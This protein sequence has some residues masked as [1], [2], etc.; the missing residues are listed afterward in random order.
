M[1][2]HLLLG[3]AAIL[4]AIPGLALAPSLA[5][6]HGGQTID[7][8]RGAGLLW[9]YAIALVAI[10]G[11]IVF[12]MYLRATRPP[13]HP[14]PSHRLA[15]LETALTS[16]LATLQNA[17]DYPSECGLSAKERKTRLDAVATIRRLI[18]EEELKSAS[19]QDDAQSVVT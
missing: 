14:R 18:E 9:F 5:F 2:H 11:F 8:D 17:E 6:A 12:R 3:T 16:N 7:H 13:G 4:S 19:A 15:E 10:V 1:R